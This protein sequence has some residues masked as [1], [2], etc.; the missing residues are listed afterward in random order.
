MVLCIHDGPW[1]RDEWSFNPLHQWLANRGYAVLS[2]NYRGSTGLGKQFTNAGNR[3]WGGKMHL[4]L[5]DAVGWAI[6]Q[7]VADPQR[8]A[9]W[10]ASFGGYATLISL[11]LTPDTFAC[12]V[13]LSGPTNLLTWV[14][15]IWQDLPPD[16][17]YRDRVGDQT[18]PEGKKDLTERSPLTYADRIRK[19]LLIGQGAHDQGVKPAETEQIVKA[20]Q[21]RKT[22]VTYLLYSEE[23][24]GLYRPENTKSFQAIAEAFLSVH[25]RGRYEPI[26]DALFGSTLHVRTGA[27]QIPG[28]AE[29]LKRTPPEQLPLP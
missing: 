24:H 14:Q 18:T 11:S 22:P 12:G 8:V 27:D 23:G 20:M 1:A 9:A 19:P 26:G 21:G 16:P 10:G 28:L 25:L 5:L 15:M 4:D 3:E 6:D 29:S 17:I 13:D 7:R 2:V